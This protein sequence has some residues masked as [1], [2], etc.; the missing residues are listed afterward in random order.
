MTRTIRSVFATAVAMLLSAAILPATAAPAGASDPLAGAPTVGECR[1][2]TAKVRMGWTEDSAAT[3][4]ASRHTGLVVKVAIAPSKYEL[5]GRPNAQLLAFVHDTCLP[6]WR[7][8]VGATHAQSHL[9][10]YTYSWFA[11]TKAQLALGARWVRCDVNIWAGQELGALPTGTPFVAGNI[12]RVDRKCLTAK[13]Y[14]TSCANAHT[15]VSRGIVTAS[16]GAYSV[17][18][19]DAVARRK[20]Q[21]TLKRSDRRYLWARISEADWKAGERHLVCFGNGR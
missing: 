11:P 14:I 2:Y 12:D 5:S 9:T 7:Q 20:C 1:T 15:W 16:K 17:E 13:G 10:A 3:D 21:G 19:Q 6:A 18:R 8:A 4:C